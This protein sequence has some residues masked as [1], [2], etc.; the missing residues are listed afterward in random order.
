MTTTVT[1]IGLGTM[2]SR[3]V[4][5]LSGVAAVSAYDTNSVAVAE[6]TRHGVVGLANPSEGAGSDVVILMLPNSDVVEAVLGEPDESGS[7]ASSLEPGTLV[8]DMGSSTPTRTAALATRFAERG[9]ALV[10][11]PVSGG[12]RKAAS[13]ELTIMAGGRREDVDRARP[14]F[15]AVGSSITHTG[16]VGSAHALK[17][18]NNLL[19]AIGLAGALEVLTVGTKFG[20][21]PRVMLEVI[22]KSTGRNQSTEVKIESAVLDG[23]FD[24]GFSLALTVKDILTATDLGASLGVSSPVSDATVAVCRA[25]LSFLED[26]SADQAEIARYLAAETGVDLTRYAGG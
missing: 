5:H 1:F 20:L 10:D 25:A 21:N 16:M 13:G 22:N 23:K 11:A 18:L 3:M 8:V 26:Q 19:S 15:E 2:G 7:L 12:P 17:A 6:A 9:V 24:V 14:L 4:R